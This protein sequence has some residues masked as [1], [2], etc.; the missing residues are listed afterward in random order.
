MGREIMKAGR[1]IVVSI[2]TDA[3]L[4]FIDTY[5]KWAHMWR[6]IPD[7]FVNWPSQVKNAFMSDDYLQENWHPHIGPGGWHDMDMFALG[8][9]FSTATSSCPNKLT[10][11][12]QITHMTAWALYPSSLILSCDLDALSDFELRLFSNEEVIAV[13][14]DRLGKSAIRV[15]EERSQVLDSRQPTREA[16]T[17]A[18]LLTDGSFAVGFFNLAESSAEL[19]IDLASI[20]FSGSVGVRNLWE[21][22]NL[23]RVQNRFSIPVSAHGAQLVRIMP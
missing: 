10:P 5:R 3:H 19:S 17:W 11:D 18:R 15:N 14:Q 4:C 1:D 12:E 6:G 9:Q 13:N 23:G 2:C 21:R 7:T 22:R 20:G 8:P 16:R